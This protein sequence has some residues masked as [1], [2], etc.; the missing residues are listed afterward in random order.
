MTVLHLVFLIGLC[1]AVAGIALAILNDV[2]DELDKRR[3]ND[4]IA[5]AAGRQLLQRRA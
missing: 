2:C 5:A 4:E 3:R 1:V